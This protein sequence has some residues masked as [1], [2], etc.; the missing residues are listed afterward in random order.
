MRV[1][2][3]PVNLQ[4]LD[5]FEL[6]TV[7]AAL[8]TVGAIIALAVIVNAVAR[9]GLILLG[10]R[11]HVAPQELL[12]VRRTITWLLALAAFVAIL[13]VLGLNVGGMWAV[14]STVLA[15]IAIGFVALW[16]VLSNILCTV[17]IMIVRPFA[18]GDEIE[19]AGEPVKGRVVDLNFIFTTLD[20]GDGTVMQV[21][22]SMFFQK[23]LRR[24]HAGAAVSAADHLRGK[25]PEQKPTAAPADPAPPLPPAA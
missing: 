16:S 4:V 6:A 24:R 17:I 13:G 5:S 20:A 8:V 18:I 3:R 23:A 22:N 11:I 19:F 21:P 1:S 10:R 25:Q 12:P 15:M 7:A 14:L 2:L 9:R